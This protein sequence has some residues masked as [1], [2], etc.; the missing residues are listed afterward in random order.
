M[1]ATDLEQGHVVVTAQLAN[2]SHTFSMPNVSPVA[3]K[4]EEACKVFDVDFKEV[5]FLQQ[6]RGLMR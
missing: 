2:P 1:V 5:F 4:L 3:G 6:M